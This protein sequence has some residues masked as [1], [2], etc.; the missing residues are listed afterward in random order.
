MTT[1][2]SDV[3]ILEGKDITASASDVVSDDVAGIASVAPP[4]VTEAWTLASTCKIPDIRFP[5]TSE[6]QNSSYFRE[7]A[8]QKD[9]SVLSFRRNDSSCLEVGIGRP[10]SSLTLSKGFQVYLYLHTRPCK[11]QSRI[12]SP[13]LLV[14]LLS[15]WQVEDFSSMACMGVDAIPTIIVKA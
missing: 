3:T 8:H 14:F 13:F 2:T 10:I 12:A 1:T 5:T 11:Q 7:S 6:L 4:L 15:L 9:N